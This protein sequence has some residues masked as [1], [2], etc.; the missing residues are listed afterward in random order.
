MCDNTEGDNVSYTRVTKIERSQFYV[1]RQ[2]GNYQTGDRQRKPGTGKGR[3]EA[4]SLADQH[5]F[6]CTDLFLFRPK[7]EAFEPPIRRRLVGGGWRHA[8]VKDAL[9]ET[10]YFAARWIGGGWRHAVVKDAL[11]ETA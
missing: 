8:V 4:P 3:M 1:L 5:P 10:A 2:S 11:Q 6:V 9:Q 7:E